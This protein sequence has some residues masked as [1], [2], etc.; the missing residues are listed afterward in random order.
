MSHEK[1]KKY[2]SVFLTVL[3]VL[4]MCACG[5]KDGESR[6][7]PQA[8][9]TA[10]PEY[11]ELYDVPYGDDELQ[12][13][14]IVM[15][16]K[17]ANR[18]VIVMIHGG[19]WTDGGK[20][21]FENIK[22]DFYKHG[23]TFAKID[24]R[25]A[26]NGLAM[27]DLLE[28]VTA[29]LAGIKQTAAEKGIGLENAMLGGIS[30]GGQMALL[31]SYSRREEAP[32]S[33]KCCVGMSAVSDMTA[34]SVWIGNPLDEYQSAKNK[35]VKIGSRLCGLDFDESNFEEAIP[36]LEKISPLAYA[37]NAVPTILAHG[38]ADDIIPYDIAVSMYNAL[39]ANGIE[40]PFVSFTNSGH[41]LESDPVC[42]I[43]LNKQMLDFADR[44]L[45]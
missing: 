18:G 10:P 7:V 12:T 40:C 11:I 28:D 2:I 45:K 5:K 15:P 19:A 25:F 42:K 20:G 29:A 35:M 32:L 9:Q 17:N 6:A 13:F 36:Y 22:I 24:Y 39:N 27:D 33:V 44:Y 26:L 31:Y 30:A 34:E 23:F 8:E 16:G 43:Q 21:E 14:D 41:M 1:I 37:E 38:V 3:I 4:G